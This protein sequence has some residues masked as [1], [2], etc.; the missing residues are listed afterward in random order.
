M[1]IPIPVL[2]RRC[3]M[4]REPKLQYFTG[5]ISR[6]IVEVSVFFLFQIMFHVVPYGYYRAFRHPPPLP[7][8]RVSTYTYI[9][10]CTYI[11]T[12]IYI[13]IYLYVHITY[14][15]NIYACIYICVF[16]YMYVY[17]YMYIYIYVC[18]CLYIYIYI[19]GGP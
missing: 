15:P 6:W 2:Q 8:N 14:N 13:Y 18:L 17:I 16:I 5:R 3:G 9:C 4:M 7:V 19:N 10:V 1:L 12:Y 11:C